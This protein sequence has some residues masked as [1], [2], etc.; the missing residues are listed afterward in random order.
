[1]E[2]V[3]I[4][5]HTTKFHT[6]SFVDGYQSTQRN[7]MIP[8]MSQTKPKSKWFNK[9]QCTENQNLLFVIYG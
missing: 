2:A 6:S 5:T 3:K 9:I 1:M 8:K 7:E 4:N